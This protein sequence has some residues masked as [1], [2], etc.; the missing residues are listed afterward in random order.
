MYI[1]YKRRD[2]VTRVIRRRGL[3]GKAKPM[4]CMC[5]GGQNSK[6]AHMGETKDFCIKRASSHP[7]AQTKTAAF[8]FWVTYSPTLLRFLYDSVR[9]YQGGKI[10]KTNKKEEVYYQPG[11]SSGRSCLGLVCSYPKSEIR[12]RGRYKE[13]LEKGNPQQTRTL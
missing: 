5:V 9:H 11:R 2:M 12:A 4:P 6:K 8:N 1:Y 10:I 7:F 3:D 13:N